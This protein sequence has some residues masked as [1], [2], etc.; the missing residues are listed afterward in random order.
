MQVLGQWVRRQ[1]FLYSFFGFETKSRYVAQSGL[2]FS[3][4]AGFL[5]KRVTVLLSHQIIH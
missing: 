1:Q 2:E 4:T 3:L 5:W